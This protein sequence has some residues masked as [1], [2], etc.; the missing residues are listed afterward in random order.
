MRLTP[1]ELAE[2]LNVNQSAISK[3]EH[4]TDMYV[5][6]LRR[7]IAAMGTTGNPLCLSRRGVRISQFEPL[8]IDE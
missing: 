5:S 4:Q 1:Q 7:C 3:L 2:I 8:A 6:M